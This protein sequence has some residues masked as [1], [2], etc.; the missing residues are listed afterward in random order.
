M[1]ETHPVFRIFDAL[2]AQIRSRRICPSTAQR[3]NQA[4][5]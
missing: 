1:D 2:R 3:S 5:Q 4:A